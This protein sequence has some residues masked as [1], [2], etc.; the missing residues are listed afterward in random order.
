M[1]VRVLQERLAKALNIVSRVAAS[2]RAALPVLSNILIRAENNKLVL[3]ATNLELATVDYLSAKVQKEGTITV[4]AKL[5]AEFVSNLPKGVD[6]E[7]VTKDNKLTVKAGQYRSVMN[8]IIADDFP[9]LPQIDEKKAVMFKVGVEDFKG[10]ITEVVVASSNDTTRPALTGVYFNTYEGAL[11][12]ASTDGYRLAERRFIE[13]VVSE[14]FTIVPTTSL[15][16]VLR[17][18]TDDVEEIEI[19]FDDTQVRFRL[20]EIEITS[21]IID[22]NFPDYR[23]LIPKKTDV[24]VDLSKEEFMRMTKMAA[25]F[26]RESGGSVVCE[27]KKID[28]QFLISAVASELGEN[29]SYIEAVVSEDGKVVLNSRF[30]MD[31]LNAIS[32]E[33]LS[34]GFSGKLSPVVIRN[35]K[36]KD[37][38]HI[39]MPLKS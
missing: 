10:A 14:V 31:A 23:Q 15:Q 26:A 13:K 32:E 38:T 28:K 5:L 21:R 25:L 39:I 4:P 1:E 17:S 16:E 8:G 24:V 19:L 27:T 34:F 22:G 18:I 36:N 20:G 30:L 7:I 11:Y 37:Y 12:I 33:N 35:A 6:V 9:E 2:T 29:T 3:T